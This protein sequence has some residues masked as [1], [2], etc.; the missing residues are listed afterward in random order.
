[1]EIK[2]VNE[3]DCPIE[4]LEVIEYL[5]E[6]LPDRNAKYYDYKAQVKLIRQMHNQYN[7]IVGFNAFVQKWIPE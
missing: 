6:N 5:Q 3:Y 1:M 4:L 2:T 7:H